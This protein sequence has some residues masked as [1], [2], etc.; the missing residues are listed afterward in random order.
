MNKRPI[1]IF[2]DETYP[3]S[4]S[5]G[6]EVIVISCVAVEHRRFLSISPDIGQ[7]IRRSR[8]TD[9][10]NMINKW[11]DRC[12]GIAVVTRGRARSI[13]LRKGEIDGT[14]EIP[15]MARRDNAWSTMLLYGVG[16]TIRSLILRGYDC[17][18]LS[19]FY[20]SRTITVPHER[21]VHRALR[22]L[23]TDVSNEFGRYVR[24][25]THVAIR[26]IR[27]LRKNDASEPRLLLI[28]THIADRICYLYRK[29]DAWPTSGDIVA[30]RFELRDVRDTL[31]RTLLRYEGE[32]GVNEGSVPPL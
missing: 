32:L 6:S 8:F 14:I 31:E 29:V 21:E 12:N 4:L 30:G 1:S 24:A 19:V 23:I 27:P 2:A 17:S 28:G 5:S 3:R 22:S 13:T 10:P 20:D 18:E 11:L 26:K 7:S 25:P 16:L 9:L 15:R